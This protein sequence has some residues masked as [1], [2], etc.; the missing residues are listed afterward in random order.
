MARNASADSGRDCRRVS[1]PRLSAVAQS[2]PR[3]DGVLNGKLCASP[4]RTLLS[5]FAGGT[6]LLRLW[7]AFLS[8]RL[9]NFIGNSLM[10]QMR[11][12]RRGKRTCSSADPRRVQQDRCLDTNAHPRSEASGCSGMLE[13]RRGAQQ[14][15]ANGGAAGG[16]GATGTS[17]RDKS[18]EQRQ[19][20]A[21][22]LGPAGDG[23]QK[24]DGGYDDVEMSRWRD[25]D[26]LPTGR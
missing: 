6:D 21:M 18:A 2:N 14:T 5:L 8:R 3:Y 22:N 25:P 16:G 26:I 12:R 17:R 15:P 24:E 10:I 20:G 11:R 7:E 13:A 4:T 9:R 23:R 1:D 19:C